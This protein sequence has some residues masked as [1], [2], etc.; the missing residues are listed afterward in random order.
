MLEK[1]IKL[2]HILLVNIYWKHKNCI[3]TLQ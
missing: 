1:I 3:I 2:W